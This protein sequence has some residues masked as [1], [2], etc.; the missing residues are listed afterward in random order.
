MIK[1]KTVLVFF[2][3]FQ[4]EHDLVENVR[5]ISAHCKYKE[6]H[7]FFEEQIKNKLRN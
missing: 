5:Q 6:I 7:I 1:I 4:I 2:L 3:Y